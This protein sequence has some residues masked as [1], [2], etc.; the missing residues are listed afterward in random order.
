MGSNPI[1]R[2]NLECASLGITCI[3]KLMLHIFLSFHCGGFAVSVELVYHLFNTKC[4]DSTLYML[5]SKFTLLKKCWMDQT[6][7]GGALCITWNLSTSVSSSNFENSQ[8]QLNSCLY[9]QNW[10]FFY[11]FKT[12]VYPLFQLFFFQS[13]W[14]FRTLMSFFSNL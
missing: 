1:W 4:P 12:F 13:H 6:L 9:H 8:N 10:A 3:L 7:V 5:I 11:Q 14:H 2:T